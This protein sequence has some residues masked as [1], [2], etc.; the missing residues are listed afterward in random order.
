M[1]DMVER[2]ARAIADMQGDKWDEIPKHKTDWVRRRG[3]FGGRFRDVNEPFRFDYE[4]MARAAIRALMEPTKEM[5]DAREKLYEI[6]LDR[7]DLDD[8]QAMLKAALDD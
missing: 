4:D 7:N 3:N 5:L 6:P 2:V 8:W 1:T